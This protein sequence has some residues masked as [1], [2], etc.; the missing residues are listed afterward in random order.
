MKYTQY[1]GKLKCFSSRRIVSTKN[2]SH[3]TFTSCTKSITWSHEPIDY[4]FLNIK[5]E[6]P[7]RITA[8]ML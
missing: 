7:K 6:N 1:I 2:S 4:I 3:F 5:R 8:T